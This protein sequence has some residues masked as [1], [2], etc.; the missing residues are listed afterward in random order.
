MSLKVGVKA[1]YSK[2]YSP[3]RNHSLWVKSAQSKPSNNHKVCVTCN[4]LGWI[5][6]TGNVELD[7]Q[8]TQLTHIHTCSDCNK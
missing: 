6:C 7:C 8:N 2:Q 4:G 1:Q 3:Y 5:Y